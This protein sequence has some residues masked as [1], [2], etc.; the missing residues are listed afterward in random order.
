MPTPQLR[1]TDEEVDRLRTAGRSWREISER[2]GLTVPEAKAAVSAIRAVR[3]QGLKER[4]AAQVLAATVC[5]ACGTP[6]GEHRPDDDGQLAC[7]FRVP[8]ASFFTTARRQEGYPVLH[9]RYRTDA[10]VH[11]HVEERLAG[12]PAE[13]SEVSGRGAYCGKVHRKGQPIPV[14]STTARRRRARLKRR[15]MA[16]QVQP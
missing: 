16:R 10:W 2:T 1:W 7:P 15:R 11:A 13:R 3:R 5:T 12:V 8:G 14:T 9:G 6:H 4:R